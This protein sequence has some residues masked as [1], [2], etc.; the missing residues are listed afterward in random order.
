MKINIYHVNT[1]DGPKDYVACLSH[2]QVFLKG[3]D[4][5]AIFG[6]LLRPLS[7]DENITPSVFTQ[8][9]V[10]VKFLHEV[11]ARRAL[12]SLSLIEEARR[13]GEGWV[14]VIDQRTRNPREAVPPEDVVGVFEVRGGC[15]VLGSY[16][17]NPG[18]MILS[19]NGFFRLSAE[20]QACLVQELG[21]V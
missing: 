21:L 4:P 18:H 6:V 20:L 15:I 7:A 17:P 1:P 14:Y 11:I 2:E 16:R 12:E 19:A 9:S 13:Q 8:N 3:L 10:F 5:K